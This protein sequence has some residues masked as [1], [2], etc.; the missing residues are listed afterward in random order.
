MTGDKSKFISL[1]L[2]DGGYVKYGDNNKGKILGAGDIGSEST[3]IIKDVLYV[4]GL[5]HNLLSLSQL[6]DKGYQVYFTSHSCTLE[7]KE[8]DSLKLV[9]EMVNNIY[10]I[11]LDSLPTNNV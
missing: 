7:H 8:D 3:T 2:K 6:C 1:N 10:M 4:K 5:K 11:D 9:G